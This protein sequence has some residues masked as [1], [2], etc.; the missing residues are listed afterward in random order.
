MPRHVVEG[1]TT[2]Q[3]CLEDRDLRGASVALSPFLRCC[4]QFTLTV[5]GK[6]RQHLRY[7]AQRRRISPNR[8]KYCPQ[9]Q[10]HVEPD[11]LHIVM[12]SRYIPWNFQLRSWI[13]LD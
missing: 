5:C 9:I 4:I 3:E 12:S 1:V 8:S 2:V 10:P 11:E 13:Q 7:A 6:C